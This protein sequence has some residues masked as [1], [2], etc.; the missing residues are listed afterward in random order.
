MNGIE[1]KRSI[2]VLFSISLLLSVIFVARFNIIAEASPKTIDVPKNYATIQEAINNANLGDAIFVHKGTYHEDIHINKTVSI[3]GEDR[4][5]TIIH[6]DKSLYAVSI[7]AYGVSVEGFT[8]KARN[9]TVSSII[10]YSAGNILRDN[11]IK[12]G[13]FGILLLG[14]TGDV[15]SGNIISNSTV[16]LEIQASFNNAVSANT[17]VNQGVGITL[18]SSNNNVFSGNTLYYNAIGLVLYSSFD[19]NIFY[20]NNFNNAYQLDFSGQA[21][22]TNVWSL[23]GEGNYWSDYVGRDLNGTG[24]GDDPYNHTDTQEGDIHPLMGPFY[25]LDVAMKTGT[26]SVYLIS[27]SSISGLEYRIGEDT[28][29]RI[30]RFYATGGEGTGGFCRIMIPLGLMESPFIVLGADGEITPKTLNASNETDTYLYFTWIHSNQTISIISSQ[31]LYL[32]NELLG[33]YGQLLADLNNLSLAH[34]ALLENY[35]ALLN[36]FIELQNRYFALNSSYSQHLSDYSKNVEN[37]QNIMYIFAA[38]AAV[39]LVTIV[40]LSKRASTGIKRRA[41]DHTDEG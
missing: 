31:A 27:N 9:N 11:R 28:G 22:S 1:L 20:H 4:D 26:Y 32:Y 36:S 14:S 34:G 18:F 2:F 23:N 41:I 30:V 5:L 39:F 25:S 7:E 37:I 10:I 12:D 3:L 35:T 24:I 29:N 16:G 15:L 21:N 33:K 17:I 8:V 38:T 19:N 6:G 40:Y 13:Y